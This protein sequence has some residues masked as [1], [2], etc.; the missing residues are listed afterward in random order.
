MLPP[1]IDPATVRRR[2]GVYADPEESMEQRGHVYHELLG[3][4]PPR[5]EAR[6]NVTGALDPTMLDLQEKI[7][8]HGMYPKCFDVKTAQLMLFGMLLMDLSDA[9]QLHGIAARRAGASWEEMQAV[10]NLAFCSAGCRQPT[11]APKSWPTSPSARRMRRKRRSKRGRRRICSRGA[12]MALSQDRIHALGDELFEAWKAAKQIAPLTER[13]PSI[14]IDDAYR[15]QLRTIERRN[16]AGERLVGK[17]IGIT[18]RAVMQMLKVEQPDFGHLLSGMAFG[19][20]ETLQANRFCQPRG[21]GEIAF[22]LKHDLTGPG[23]TNADVLAATECVMPAFEIVDSRVTDWKIKI[24]DTVADNG[25][26]A[27][28]VLGDNARR[29]AQGRPR[30]SGHGAREERRGHRHRCRRRLARQPG[31]RRHLAR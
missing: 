6:L 7:R 25:S 21:E 30:D 2:I 31:Q 11:A 10:I 22:I 24:Q 15:V 27:A 29:S 16:E 26:A 23:L 12:C 5:I 3:F 17:K 1:R 19:E 18:S 13:E 8:E 9:A 4:V 20:G 28:F 14:T